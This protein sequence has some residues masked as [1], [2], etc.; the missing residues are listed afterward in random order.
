MIAVVPAV[1]AKFLF[2]NTKFA[3]AAGKTFVIANVLAT[4]LQPLLF[5]A[6]TVILPIGVAVVEAPYGTLAKFTVKIFVPCPLIIFTPL[7][8]VQ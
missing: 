7:G 8:T 4:V 5:C 1:P 2:V 6:C 3:G